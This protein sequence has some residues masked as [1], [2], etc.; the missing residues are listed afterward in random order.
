MN[1]LVTNDDGY[2]SKGILTLVRIM[3]QFGKVT[4]IA[5]KRHQSGMGMAVSLGLKQIAYKHLGEIEGADWSYL[6]AT[7]ASCVKYGLNFTF[8]DKK[9]D[10]VV[11]GIN[12]GSNASTA[13]CYSG[14][15]GAAAEA[16]LNEIPAI[17]VSLSTMDPDADF[18]GVEKYLPEIINKVLPHL[19][20]KFGSYININF[21]KI[22][23]EEIKGVKVC[24]MG[25][26]KW[27]K[28]FKEWDPGLF[29]KYGITPESL[30]QTSVTSAEEGEKLYMMVGTYHDY[31]FAPENADNIALENGYIS[32]VSHNICSEDI[33]M[34]QYLR[35]A[36]IDKDFK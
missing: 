20:K 3:R 10:L 15:L 2:Q 14:T 34:N 5:P 16:A 6:D 8:L 12:H 27:V 18:S 9:P 1:I 11:C 22:A 33:T 24:D 31:P 30:G 32:V 25:L 26:G 35:E 7:P 23:T 36:G 17:G 21:P 19:G 29:A 4:V 28:E 13:A